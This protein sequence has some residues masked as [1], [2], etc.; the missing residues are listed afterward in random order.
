VANSVEQIERARCVTDLR[1]VEG[2][3]RINGV[4]YGPN[5][6]WV[7]FRLPAVAPGLYSLLH[8]NYP[9]TKRL[10]DITWGLFWVGPPDPGGITTT[11][12]SASEPAPPPTPPPTPT[13]APPTSPPTTTTTIAPTPKTAAQARLTAAAGSRGADSSSVP[14]TLVALGALALVATGAV[15]LVRRRTRR[16]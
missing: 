7:E 9:C 16:P 4:G 1:I 6:A 8:C 5:V 11:G 13:P 12:Q 15:T 14:S 10:G 2:G 3:D